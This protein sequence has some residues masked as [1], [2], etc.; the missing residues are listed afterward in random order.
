MT[1]R[2]IPPCTGEE[3]QVSRTTYSDN[4]PIKTHLRGT[5]DATLAYLI[6]FIPSIRY[7]VN[8]KKHVNS[9]NLLMA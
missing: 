9:K 5:G 3:L 1:V 2:W 4:R 6:N 7:N 8:V